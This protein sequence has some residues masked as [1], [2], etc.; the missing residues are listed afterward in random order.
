MNMTLQ[1]IYDKVAKHLLA[2]N[3]RSMSDKAQGCAYRGEN[4]AMCA[5]G[6]LIKDEYYSEAMEGGNIRSVLVQS[7]LFYS[8]INHHAF[9]MLSE[10][11]RIHDLGDIHEW[12]DDIIALADVYSLT[13][14]GD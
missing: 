1:E 11:Q 10:L 9:K 8:G 13:P 2:Q 12:R 3:E 14:I 4:G 5:I 7:A 6:C